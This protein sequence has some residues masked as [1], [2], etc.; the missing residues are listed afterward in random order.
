TYTMKSYWK[1]SLVNQTTNY[2]PSS[3]LTIPLHL[4]VYR[5]DFSTRF[6]DGNVNPLPQPPS[7][8]QLAYPNGTSSALD[9]SGAYLLPAGTYS[10]SSVTW[11]GINVAA[12]PITFNPKLRLRSS[13]FL[14][15]EGM[16]RT[17]RGLTRCR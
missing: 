1:G 8:I 13:M 16:L 9:P 10:I 15:G 6:L 5:L 17:D 11:E 7:V 4:S 14:P 12:S 3:S 2:N